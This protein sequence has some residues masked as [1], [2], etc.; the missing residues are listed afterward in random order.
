VT[1]AVSKPT[2]AKTS[3]RQFLRLAL[4]LTESQTRREQLTA[5]L[6]NID[7]SEDD[8]PYESWFQLTQPAVAALAVDKIPDE[9]LVKL[10][11]LL[12]NLPV[13]DIKA[14]L[15]TV[16]TPDEV[17]QHEA[18]IS[19]RADLRL[20][21]TNEIDEKFN[22]V[23]KLESAV[24]PGQSVETILDQK[25]M[26]FADLRF[27]LIDAFRGFKFT[28]ETKTALAK[29]LVPAAITTKLDGLKDKPFETEEALAAE[30]VPLLTAPERKLYSG[31]IL[32]RGREKITES[33]QYDRM[34]AIVGIP[35]AAK[36]VDHYAINLKLGE[37]EVQ[38][39]IED[40][41]EAFIPKYRV[42]LSEIAALKDQV[43]DLTI[44]ARDAADLLPS[45]AQIVKEQEIELADREDKLKKAKEET[46]ELI[47]R[48]KF[49][50]ESLFKARQELRDA[51]AENQKLEQTLRTMEQAR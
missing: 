7:Q 42:K 36:A 9:V 31:R 12:G 50:E 10:E 24:S 3:A 40:D 20:V 33:K 47:K 38:R 46:A 1:E 13:K 32:N 39:R 29:D 35:R 44:V 4:A 43:A 16:L 11:K 18:K 6:A 25:K 27:R 8:K 23:L 34:L 45:R 41:R 49:I 28:D 22:R 14:P 30:F 2:P 17:M 37:L 26:V 48:Q 21:I 19:E 51:F 5:L 15:A